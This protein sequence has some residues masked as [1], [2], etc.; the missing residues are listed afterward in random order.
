M[1]AES[2]G[3]ISHLNGHD[4][5]LEQVE[6]DKHETLCSILRVANGLNCAVVCLDP[7]LEADGQKTSASYS[8]VT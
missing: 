7:F 2:S 4:G 6:N 8:A 5:R 1:E 3:R